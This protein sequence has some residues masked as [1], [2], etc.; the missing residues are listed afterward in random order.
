MMSKE[1]GKKRKKT[2]LT[3][4]D[5]MNIIKLIEKGTSYAIISECY[6]IGRLTVCDTNKNKES[7]KSF[8]RRWQRWGKEKWKLWKLEVMRS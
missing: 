5:K 7:L 1:T 6:G 2:A 4:E 8:H 3:I